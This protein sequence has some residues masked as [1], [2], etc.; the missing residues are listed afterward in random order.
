MEFIMPRLTSL[1]LKILNWVNP[2][3][4]NK[5]NKIII[6]RIELYKNNLKFFKV[7][8]QVLELLPQ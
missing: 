6:L 3:L 5:T 4:F 2:G 1:I 8:G 7:R